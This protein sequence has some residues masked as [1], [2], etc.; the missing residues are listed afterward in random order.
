MI[1][2]CLYRIRGGLTLRKDFC[3]STPSASLYNNVEFGEDFDEAEL[4][5]NPIY[6]VFFFYVYMSKIIF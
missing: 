5:T 3:N 1:L 2:L 4:F 6:E